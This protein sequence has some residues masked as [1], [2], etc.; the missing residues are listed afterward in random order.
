ME[1]ILKDDWFAPNATLYRRNRADRN[2]PVSIPDEFA[3]CLP[4]N[5][6]VVGKDHFVTPAVEREVTLRDFDSLRA[7]GEAEDKLIAEAMAR[8]QKKLKG[9]N[10]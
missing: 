7:A 9:D 1:V 10:R 8:A 2:K 4:P 3:D 6:K 5:A